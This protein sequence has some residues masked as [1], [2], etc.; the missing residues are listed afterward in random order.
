[1]SSHYLS[2]ER[3]KSF[4]RDRRAGPSVEFALTAPVLALIIMGVIAI[5]F[6][7]DARSQAREAVRAGAHAVMAGE[8]DTAVIQQIVLSALARSPEGYVVQVNRQ[9]RC[10]STVIEAA[11]VVQEGAVCV[12][13]DDPQEFFVINLDAPA[14]VAYLDAPAISASIEVR[15]A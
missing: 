11:T 2:W 15:V 7:V 12:N 9:F 4:A 13:G 3:M 10:V 8:T 1:M 6:E 5:G 14:G